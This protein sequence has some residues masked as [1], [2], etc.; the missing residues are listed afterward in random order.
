[1]AYCRENLLNFLVYSIKILPALLS[2]LPCLVI[3][4]KSRKFLLKWF[5][6]LTF[7]RHM[8]L[9]LTLTRLIIWMSD[10]NCCRTSTLCLIK[11]SRRLIFFWQFIFSCQLILISFFLF[12]GVLWVCA[13]EY[14]VCLNKWVN[15][16]QSLWW[17][18]NFIKNSWS[19]DRARPLEVRVINFEVSLKT[20]DFLAYLLT[21]INASLFI[22]WPLILIKRSL[23]SLLSRGFLWPSDECCILQ[24]AGHRAVEVV[25]QHWLV[26]RRHINAI[27]LQSLK[28]ARWF[29]SVRILNNTV[30]SLWNGRRWPTLHQLLTLSV[31]ILHL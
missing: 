22:W 30:D 9:N 10:I 3:D 8:I 12:R 13:L 6:G 7:L 17:I 18:P 16:N 28:D 21:C 27:L 14:F 20:V 31:S 1:M 15:F 2:L 5:A 23:E 25:R 24:R 11:F 4:P 29:T 26:S 19:L